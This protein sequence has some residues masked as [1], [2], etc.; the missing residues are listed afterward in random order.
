MTWKSEGRNDKLRN[1]VLREQASQ[2][3]LSIA[4]AAAQSESTEV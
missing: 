2:A 4:E 1:V 3:G